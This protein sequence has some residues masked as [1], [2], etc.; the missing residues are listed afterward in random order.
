MKTK[1]KLKIEQ[2][3]FIFLATFT[4]LGT[5]AQEETVQHDGNNEFK[6]NVGSLLVDFPE[7]SYEHIINEESSVGIS[8]AF[9]LDKEISYRFMIYPNYRIY[10]G[11]KRAAGFFIEANS[12]IFSQQEQRSTFT[13][14]EN[15]GTNVNKMG[16]GLGLAIGG[17]FLTK[18][19]FI[20][21]LYIGGGRNFMNTD[22]IDSGYPRIGISIGKRF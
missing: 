15:A 6:I 14:N 22:K 17:K 9:P 8:I 11:K 13:L 19:G 10:F 20:G 4:T 21:E 18:K 16:L 12:A 1:F 5:L 7:L 3:L 2:I